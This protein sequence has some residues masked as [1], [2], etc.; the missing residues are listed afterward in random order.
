MTR[1]AVKDRLLDAQTL[2]TAGCTPYGG[3]DIGECLAAARSVRGTDLDSWYDAWSALAART[4]D[5]AEREAAA[6]RTETARLAF[7]RASSYDRNAGV[8]LLR[9]PLDP[10]LMAGNARQ[11]ELFRR[12]AALMA[13]PPKTVE[14]RLGGHD[15][16]RLLLPLR[17]Q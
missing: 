14:P 16:A 10:R 12:G 7:W 1:F 17:R 15:A 8:M 3:A 9:A 5:L 6:G 13:R 11:T 2:R 4:A